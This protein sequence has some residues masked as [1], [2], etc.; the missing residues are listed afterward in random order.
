MAKLEYEEN[1]VLSDLE[2]ACVSKISNGESDDKIAKSLNLSEHSIRHVLRNA[3]QKLGA[4]HAA[5]AVAIALR[6]GV[7]E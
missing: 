5:Q 2:L 6:K 1:S 7:I 4:K 3:A